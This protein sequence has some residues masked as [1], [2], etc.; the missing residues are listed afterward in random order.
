MTQAIMPCNGVLLY[1]YD[2]TSRHMQI[3]LT[4]RKGGG[5]GL[6]F[7][8]KINQTEILGTRVGTVI[9]M[10]DQLY[11]E[12]IE[13]LGAKALNNAI[14]LAQFRTY[15]Q[16]INT[17]LIRVTDKDEDILAHSSSY[18]AY[19]TT[20][21]ERQ[22]LTNLPETEER[23]GEI[24]WCELRW[25]S[26]VENDLERQTSVSLSHKERDISFSVIHHRHEQVC[27]LHAMALL[28]HRKRLWLER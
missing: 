27:V 21:M 7:G 15:V 6:T 11:Q 22:M 26:N 18:Y 1:Q 23:R 13:E 10:I 8:G 9:D 19:Q 20:F 25:R 16:P 4:E 17:S 24:L 2:G 28:A 5:Y 12:G 14:S 3:A